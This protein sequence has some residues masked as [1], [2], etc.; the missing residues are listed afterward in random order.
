MKNILK[1]VARYKSS[2]HILFAPLEIGSDKAPLIRVQR[3]EAESVPFYEN[4]LNWFTSLFCSTSQKRKE[5][6]FNI[7]NGQTYTSLRFDSLVSIELL[8]SSSA[9]GVAEFETVL[10]NLL[11][12]Y[13]K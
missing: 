5:Y 7:E 2:E 9:K 13:K 12:R 10:Q 6:Y 1:I 11:A 8:N 3:T 4:K